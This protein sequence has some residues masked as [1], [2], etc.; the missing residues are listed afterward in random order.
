[1][2]AQP[3][4][5]ALEKRGID[6]NHEANGA[7]MSTKSHYTLHSQDINQQIT[8]ADRQGQAAVQEKLH[9]LGNKLEER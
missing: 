7:A 5:G 4:R 9:E 6:V 2:G 3:A 8:E 1:M